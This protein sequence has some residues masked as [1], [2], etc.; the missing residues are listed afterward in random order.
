MQNQFLNVFEPFKS[1]SLYV[2]QCFQPM[3][4]S[5]YF[6]YSHWSAAK[7]YGA[8]CKSPCMYETMTW[9]RNRR[10]AKIGLQMCSANQLNRKKK[11]YL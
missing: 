7:P 2:S 1:Q 10:L 4:T 11:V 5:D 3:T 9:Y 6:T 8:S